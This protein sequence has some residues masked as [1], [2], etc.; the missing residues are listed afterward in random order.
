MRNTLSEACLYCPV[1]HDT[2]E[3]VLNRGP[4]LFVRNTIFLFWVMG[5]LA[6]CTGWGAGVASIPTRPIGQDATKLE[7]LR[8]KYSNTNFDETLRACDILGDQQKIKDCQVR[9][10]NLI[11]EELMLLVDYSYHRYEGNLIAGRAKW[12][13]SL[14]AA[15]QALNWASTTSTVK[16]TKTLY[17]AISGLV[18][19]TATEFDKNF[20]LEQTSYAL[21]Y[22]MSAARFTKATELLVGM[23]KP[24]AEYSLEKGLGIL[25]PITER[26][27][28]PLRSKVFIKALRS[29][30]TVPRPSEKQRGFNLKGRLSAGFRM[31]PSIKTR[32]RTT[33]QFSWGAPTSAMF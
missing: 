24:Y 2:G 14:G 23:T 4:I 1:T 5:L 18:S 16:G 32:N 19:S 22:Q 8:T 26:E 10:R 12:T 30:S 33:L 20:Y 13:F 6:S 25:K 15:S 7:A 28:S 11:L 31:I 9:E 3:N 21:A 27:P 29:K 17:S